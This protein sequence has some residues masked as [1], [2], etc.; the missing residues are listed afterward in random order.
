MLTS[1]TKTGSKRSTLRAQVLKGLVVTTVLLA[2]MGPATASAGGWFQGRVTGVVTNTNPSLAWIEF[3]GPIPAT[4]G[5]NTTNRMVVD[6]ATVGGK[7]VLVTAMAAKLSAA[8]I[9][10]AGTGS[11]NLHPDSET[12]GT[13][14]MR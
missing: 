6:A 3:S 10:A 2:G 13:L 5:C 1:S 8:S 4:P 11:C 9:A 12:L 7:N 14:W